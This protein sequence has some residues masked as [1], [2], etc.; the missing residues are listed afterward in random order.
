MRRTPGRIPL[1]A[2]LL[3]AS[4]PALAAPADAPFLWRNSAA[5]TAPAGLPRARG[6]Q[7]PAAGRTAVALGVEIAS[8]FTHDAE[9]GA[10]AVVDVETGTLL[11]SVEQGFRGGWSAGIELPLLR[12][13]GGFLDSPIDAYHEA[14][15]LP[16]G[17]RDR[18]PSNEVF[19]AWRD[20]SGLRR[21]LTSSASG[22]GD[23]RIHFGRA[24]GTAPDRAT[25][26]RFGV[27][28]PT[29]RVRDLAG[30][31]GLDL[32]AAL[33][34]TDRRLLSRLGWTLHGA[35]GVLAQLDRD[36]LYDGDGEA[37]VAFGNLSLAWPVSERWTI[38][39]QLDAHSRTADTPLRQVGGWSVQALLGA[40]VRL[41][42]RLHFE[43]GFAED[44]PPG[45]APDIAFLFALRG[46]L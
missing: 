46:E 23:L 30:N 19:V 37:L 32:S 11:L 4:V 21:S 45:S 42:D 40:S 20:A 26:L 12:Q 13:D 1:L 28:L 27:E 39:G 10:E 41:T 35:A 36:A 14:L 16:D 15:G 33:H 9:G 18:R 38:K 5:F 43:G 44:L 17:G 31:D 25:A 34:L 3:H 6:A 29:G 2:M 7:L 8:Q 24:L 22:V